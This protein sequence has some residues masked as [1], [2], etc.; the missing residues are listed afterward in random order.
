MYSRGI[1]V[2]AVLFSLLMVFLFNLLVSKVELVTGRYIASGIPPI[3]A[4]ATLAA[5]VALYPLGRLILGRY[6]LSRQE[7]LVIYC[8]MTIAIPLCGTYGL[9]SIL[10]RLTVMQYYATPENRFD[11][12]TAMIPSWYAPT[13]PEVITGMYE[14]LD[15]G[16]VPWSAWLKPLALW[17]AFFL[18]LFVG[19]MSLISIMSRQWSEGEHLPYPLVQLPMEMVEATGARGTLA[20]FFSNPLTWVGIALALLYNGLNIANAFNPAVPAIPQN[21]SLAEFFTERPWSAL[22]PLTVSSAPQFY[23]FGFLVSREL[24]FSIFACT[25]L[26]KLT[27]VLGAAAGFEPAGWPYMQEQSAG[28]YILMAVLMLWVARGHLRQVFAKALGSAPDVD[29]SSEPISYRWAVIGMVA[30]AIFFL[31]WTTVSG[32]SLKIALPF[33][34]IVMSYGLTYARVRAE[35]GVPDNFVYPYRFPQYTIIYSIGSRG[36]L[37]AGGPVTN[38]VFEVLSF[39]SRF[40]PV[41]IMTSSQADAYQMAR[42][43][44]LN[45]RKLSMLLLLAFALGLIFAFWGHFTTFYSIGLNVLEG[46]PRSADWRTVDTVTAYS[47]MVSQIESPTGPDWHRTGAIIA[48][49]AITLGLAIARMVWLRFPIHPLGYIVALS[50]GPSTSLWFPFLVVWLV[51]GIIER[52]G[53]LRLFRRLIPLFIGYVVAH[54]VFGGIGWSIISLFI[55]SAVSSRYYTV[56]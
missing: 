12:Y 44:R 13:S 51:K 24:C 15:T 19:T 16:S 11:D 45:S 38:V 25:F 22:N 6:N 42:A 27:A 9:R 50:Y 39:L 41:Q 10:P 29:D 53:G 31:V 30:S 46:N 35:M 1:T 3:P 40:H 48:G 5:L 52:I 7:L 43:G 55:E 32:M 23:G 47:G 33:Y 26:A 37:N 28:G 54:Y 8:L 36:V 14:G 17:S 2:R 4:V 20:N 18:A 49:A 56:F 21:K 34:L